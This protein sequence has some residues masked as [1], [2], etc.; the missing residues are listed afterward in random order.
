MLYRSKIVEAIQKLLHISLTP[1]TISSSWI[2]IHLWPF[3]GNEILTLDKLPGV[4][5]KGWHIERLKVPDS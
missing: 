1:Y 3:V 2:A 4:L 5:E